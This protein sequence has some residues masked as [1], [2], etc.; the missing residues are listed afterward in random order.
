MKSENLIE[1]KKMGVSPT[2]IKRAKEQAQKDMREYILDLFREFFVESNQ[3]VQEAE[4]NMNDLEN[5]SF[6][7]LVKMKEA[8]CL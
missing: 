1:S 2:V 4:T 3:T 6:R 7:R 5:M 8:F